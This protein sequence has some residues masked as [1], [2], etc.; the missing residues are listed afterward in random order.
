ME[1]KSVLK[2]PGLGP[3]GRAMQPRFLD[4]GESAFGIVI[5]HPGA[6]ESV[7]AAKSTR[8]PALSKAFA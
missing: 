2:Q 8:P 4:K 3:I 7:D 5:R 1:P 6:R